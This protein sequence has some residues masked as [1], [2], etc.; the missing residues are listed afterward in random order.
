MIKVNLI[1]IKEKKKRKELLV[2]FSGVAISIAVVLVLAYIYGT[3]LRE[4]DALNKQIADVQKESEG[5]QDKI[6]E[7]KDLESKE[8]SLE[9]FKKTIKGISETQRKIIV[10]MDQLALNLPEGIWFTSIVQGRGADFNKFTLQGYTFSQMALQKYCDDLR[11]PGGLLKDVTCDI[12]SMAA[13][14]GT[15][16][17]IQQF[18]ISAKVPDQ[19]S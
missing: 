1:P 2:V 13:A 8:A 7:I 15:N 14:V 11:R 12:K 9:A 18:E 5:Y 3:R 16:K 6:N 19:G 4:A 17:Q 10:A